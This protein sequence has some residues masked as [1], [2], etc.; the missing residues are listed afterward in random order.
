MRII[1][2]TLGGRRLKAPPGDATRPTADRVREALFSILGPPPAGARVLDLC[3][4]AGGLGLEALSRGAAGAVFVD[5]DRRALAALRA[6]LAALGLEGT[7]QV[8]AGDAR[9]VLRRLAGTF[10]WVFADPP[11]RS[12][13]ADLLVD[14]LS[15]GRLLGA[16]AVVVIEH[17]R[18]LPPAERHGCLVRTDL[19]RYGD[20]E[21]SFFRRR[22]EP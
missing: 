7:S 18:R 19:R 4:G 16:G 9:T 12:G 14:D 22:S 11:Y 5:S 6:N 1:A 21:L 13:L 20:S 10:H 2:G 17:D 15:D 8:H 3:A